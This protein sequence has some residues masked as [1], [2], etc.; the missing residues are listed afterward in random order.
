M[1]SAAHKENYV[2]CV[3]VC[4]VYQPS[5]LE[6]GTKRSLKVHKLERAVTKPKKPVIYYL[7]DGPNRGFVCEELLVVPPGTQLPPV[8]IQ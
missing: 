6:G 3:V 4:P 5:K 1:F 7:F 8:N 2:S